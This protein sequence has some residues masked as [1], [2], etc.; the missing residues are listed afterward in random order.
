MRIS[1]LL[2]VAGCSLASVRGPDPKWTA[3]SVKAPVCDQYPWFPI[4]ID[5]WLAST[6]AATSVVVALKEGCNGNNA[7]VSGCSN[8][9]AGATAVIIL[10]T[11]AASAF[12]ASAIAGYRRHTE[13][14]VARLDYARELAR[15]RQTEASADQRELEQMRED[16]AK[17]QR[18]RARPSKQEPEPPV[19]PTSGSSRE[20]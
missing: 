6:I 10:G 8:N 15:E 13:C 12:A 17:E 1:A 20:P 5:A 16:A 14:V 18:E 11:A 2:A 4:G 9:P 7:Y 19:D 3:E